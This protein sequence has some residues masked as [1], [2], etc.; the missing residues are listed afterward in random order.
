[1]RITPEEMET[2]VEMLECGIR[3]SYLPPTQKHDMQHI[4][5]ELTTCVEQDKQSPFV[6]GDYVIVQEPG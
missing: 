4:L 2:L 5:D 1:M 3:N 6:S